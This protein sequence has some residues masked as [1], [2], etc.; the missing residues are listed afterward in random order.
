MSSEWLQDLLYVSSTPELR[1]LVSQKTSLLVPDPDISSGG[2]VMIKITLD[3]MFCLTTEVVTALLEFLEQFGKLGLV[4]IKGENVPL[5]AK[6]IVI[7][8]TR[9]A[10][11]KELPNIRQFYGFYKEWPCLLSTVFAVLS[12]YYWIRNE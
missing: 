8:A 5:I 2:A 10:E 7:V 11:V 3:Q 9:L 12:S 4:K 6:Q 1:E